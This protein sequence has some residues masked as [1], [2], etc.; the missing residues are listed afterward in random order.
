[1]GSEAYV[2]RRV[3]IGRPQRR[4]RNLLGGAV[5][6]IPRGRRQ[7]RGE[8]FTAFLPRALWSGWAGLPCLFNVTISLLS[9]GGG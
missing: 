8:L 3:V 9:N 1:M 7:K 6:G 2:L 4:G 5:S